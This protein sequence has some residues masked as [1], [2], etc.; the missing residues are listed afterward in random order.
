MYLFIS[1]ISTHHLSLS[2][3]CLLSHQSSQGGS[4]YSQ[5]LSTCSTPKWLSHCHSDRHA[6]TKTLPPV[7]SCPFSVPCPGLRSP[8]WSDPQRALQFNTPMPF[9]HVYHMA[10]FLVCKHLSLAPKTYLPK[11]FHK[12]CFLVFLYFSSTASSP[13]YLTLLTHPS[14]VKRQGVQWLRAETLSQCSGFK[15]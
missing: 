6:P 15:S 2:Y 14:A 12:C 4:L 13:I 7:A 5:L 1:T 3:C 11:S 8:V 9:P 10:L